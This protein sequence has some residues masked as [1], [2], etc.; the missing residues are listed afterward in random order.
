MENTVLA[1][2]GL[3][4]RCNYMPSK[5]PIGFQRMTSLFMNVF[6]G[7]VLGCVFLFL[8]NDVATMSAGEVARTFF[9]SLVMSIPVGY[10]VGDFLPTIDWGHRLTKMLHV[11]GRL[12]GHMVV[13][14][15]LAVVNVTAILTVCMLI[16]LVASVGIAEVLKVVVALWLPAV[17]S[18]FVA[19]FVLLPVAQRLASKASGYVPDTVAE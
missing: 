7:I 2:A 16:V 11:N 18:G 1:V 19:I 9:R 3:P 14:L 12:A 8:S 17:A 10:A 13:S 5:G 6:I 4:E 15:T